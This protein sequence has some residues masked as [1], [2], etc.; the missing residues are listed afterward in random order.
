[1]VRTQLYLDDDVYRLLKQV[2]ARNRKTISELLREALRRIYGPNQ[3]FAR[4]RALDAAFGMW[5]G[6]RDLGDTDRYVRALR[7]DTR[8][9][10]L[11]TA[12]GRD[13]DPR[14]PA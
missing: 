6:R 13:D 5:K 7:S 4:A 8:R 2:S 14:R 3:E 12:R 9:K 10:S 11:Q 1:V